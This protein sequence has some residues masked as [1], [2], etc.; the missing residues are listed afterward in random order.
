MPDQR[1]RI[2]HGQLTEARVLGSVIA[3][4]SD[5]RKAI[6]S[7]LAVSKASVCRMV[8]RLLERGLLREGNPVPSEGRG[9][10]A[11]LLQA[12]PD[13]GY[14]VGADLEGLA[15]RVRVLDCGRNILASRNRAIDPEWSV[16]RILGTWRSLISEAI[17]SANIAPDRLIALGV[18]LPGMASAG[19]DVV[20][21]Y[22]PPGRL[23]EFDVHEELAGFGLP[24]VASDNT[25]CVS[26]FERRLGS[27]CDADSFLSVLVRYGIGA[28]IFSRGRFIVG[29]ELAASDLGHM[30]VD[31]NGPLC[32]CGRRGCL[33]AY[34]S[35]RTWPGES[36]RSGSAWED[37]LVE[38]AHL[39]GLGIGNLLKLVGS[40]R[41]VVNGIYNEYESII[42]E[43]LEAAIA[44]DLSPLGIEPPEIDFGLSLDEK[45]CVGAAVRA[46][47]R[48]IEGYFERHV[49]VGADTS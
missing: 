38:R 29:E 12:A 37:S 26:E 32:V 1:R 8:D 44:S 24:I 42:R 31:L 2:R 11:A 28:A 13:F 25:L 47:D 18:A 41:V 16:Q 48:E 40:P 5:S 9:R 35:G 21:T 4:A 23:V 46:I 49:K 22:L 17:A 45:T 33:D 43:P 20:R 6:E 34:C 27:A 36:A 30:R 3:G 7:N 15:L 39:L 19:E 10:N 14:V